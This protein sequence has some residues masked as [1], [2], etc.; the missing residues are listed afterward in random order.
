MMLLIMLMATFF[1]CCHATVYT[2][3]W[4]IK[5]TG[6]QKTVNEIAEK[7]GF[8]NM[9]QVG[10]L[11]SYYSFW[12]NETAKRSTMSNDGLTVS[13]SKETKVKWLQQQFVQ[14]RVKRA[15]GVRQIYSTKHFSSFHLPSKQTMPLHFNNS[16]WSRLWFIHCSDRATGCRTH[17]NIAG[18]WNRGYTGKGV[19]VSVLD[20]G[21][22]G[23]H[24]DLKPNYDPLASY[25]VNR[26]KQTNHITNYH[27]TQCA[28]II[29]A[30]NN[31][32]CTV[33]V[34]FHARIG[35]I[36]I[37]SDDVTDIVE[38]QSLSF[39]PHYIDI[40]LCTWGPEDDGITVEGP[41][42]LT[43]LALQHGV[44]RGRRGR[45]SIFLWASGNG[46][47][48]G[49]H[50]SCDGY[51]SSI[52]TVAISAAMWSRAR[53][54]F[55]E[56]CPSTLTTA[57][58]GGDGQTLMTVGD[59]QTCVE[60]RP[61]SAL[62]ASAAAGVIALTLE[63]NPLLTWRDVQHII[64]RTSKTE[65]LEAPDW[66]IN[67]AGYRVNHLY[68]FGLMDAE[69]MVK[70]AER[71]KQVP[72]QHMCA[73]EA[74]VQQIRTIYPGSVMTSVFEATGCAGNS[75]KHVTYTEHVIL[76]VTITHRRRGNLSIRLISPSGTIS[77]LLAHRPLDNSSEGFQNWE[78]MTTHCWGEPPNGKWTLKI[79]DISSINT[80]ERGALTKWSL[81]IYGTAENPY[82]PRKNVR[83]VEPFDN[84]LLEEY[85]GPCD[86]ECT[87]D[88]C[89]GP[90]PQQCVACLHLFLKFKNGTRLCVSECS[91]GFWGDRRRCK[92]CYATCENCTGSRSDQCTSCQPGHHLTEGTNTCTT[93][94]GEGYYLDHDANMC[95]KCS[96]N[97]L[98][99]TTL[100]ICTECKQ[101][102]SLQGNQC[103]WSCAAGF[104]HD[105][106][107]GKCKPCHKACATCA[108]PGVESCKHCAK[109]YL[110]EEWRCVH[111][112]SV[113]FYATEPSPEMA[114]G[115]R[116]CRRCDASCSACVGPGP[117]NCSRCS[118]GHSHQDGVCVLNTE[119]EEGEY[120]DTDGKCHICDPTCLKCTG[121]QSSNCISCASSR[122]LDD[123]HCVLDCAKGKYQSGGLCYLCDHT[124][125]TCSDSGPTNCTSCDTDKFGMARYLFMGQCV[126]VCPES[127]YHTKE[128]SCE[129]CSDHCQLCSGPTHC[130]KCNSSYY[131]SDGLCNK[132]ECG[133]GEVEDP[134]YDDCMACEEGC[135]KCVLYNPKHCQS[136]IEGFYNF[137]DGCFR[138]CPA[139][140]YSVEEDMTCISCDEKCV[141]CD[142]HEC[143]WCESDL[144][145]SEGR[146]VEV[147]PD[148]FYGD[149]DTNDCEEC[150]SDCVTCSGPEDYDCESCEDGKT[151]ENGLCVFEHEVC[152]V[153]TYRSDDGECEDCH[154]S[155]EA[156]SGDEENQCTKCAKDRFLSPQQTCVMKCP[157]AHFANRLNNV[158]DECSFGCSTCIDTQ[159]CTRCYSSRNSPLYLQNGQCVEQCVRGYPAGL[160]CR[161]CVEGC[162]SCLRN[163]THCLSC[164]APL[165][166]HKHQCVEDC[167]AG[168]TVRD[169]ECH[170]C[171]PACP[172]CNPLGHCIECEE[173]HFL[174]EG[175]CVLDCPERFFADTEQRECSHCH[176]D[177]ALCDGPNNNDC[178]SCVD[179][180]ATLHNGACLTTCT[181][182]TY[183][184]D[185]SGDCN[186][187]DA[188]CLTCSGPY[189]DSCTS[190]RDGYRLEG[191]GHCAP[192]THSQCTVHQYMDQSG[193][194]HPC[195]KYCHRCSGPGTNHC[196]TCNQGHLL[197]NG[198]CFD[199]C[200]TGYY[201]D[202][203]GL[204]CEPCH[205]SCES[206]IGKHSHECLSCKFSLFR[207]AKECVETCQHGHYGNAASRMC[208]K[209]HP[210]CSECLG[211]EDD[212]CLSCT[213][214]LVYLRRAGRCLP[215][216]PEDYHHDA[217]H[218]T[219]EPCHSTCKT[220]LGKES[221]SCQ[222][223]HVGYR[224]SD[225]MC[226]SMCYRG[227]YPVIEGIELACE[228]CD[229][230]CLEC[231]G[232]GP[233]SCTLCPPQ[234]MLEPGGRCL[235]CCSHN[236]DDE[237]ADNKGQLQACC[238]C[239]ESQGECVLS[240]NLAFK[241]DVEDEERG[242]LAV[243]VT[244][245]I[246]LVVVLVAIVFLIR[247][248]RSKSA[249]RD[250]PP[251]G[252]EKLGSGGFGGD[253]HGYS[254]AS[255]TSFGGGQSG[256][257]GGRFQESQM[258]DFSDRRSGNKRND[259][260]DDD[261]ED[262][263]YMGQD[264]TVYRKFK[265]G[266]LGDDNEDE[267]EYDDESYTFR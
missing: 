33:G 262:I 160:V 265:Y 253:R 105:K 123:G 48:S 109:G 192:V 130:L 238:N 219:C 19:V 189:S 82:V 61:S 167:P 45:G 21:V 155:C 244:A 14:K 10:D 127:F 246:L 83:S 135:K 203:M 139:K 111:S 96:E 237:G 38:A 15:S 240:T 80:A 108:G 81:V 76:R 134:D 138:H 73:E 52:Y 74:S 260:D 198:T 207:E 88:G 126:D 157:R 173:Y 256:S 258:V 177:C 214:G 161:S 36:N 197:L 266:Q 254:S 129:P 170:R 252:Y 255:S 102:T 97:C 144:F 106:Q 90:G 164:D 55:Q 172:E 58:S 225:G 95:R 2:N 215:A 71:W 125:I 224:L 120:P 216:C 196:L 8:S 210:S 243:F 11:V 264:G 119:C 31:S 103:L 208:E 152:P 29:A 17:M 251:R 149:E 231:W 35:G 20:D 222:S 128:K 141:S 221:H 163:S 24:L 3:E 145:L 63:A 233:S 37:L 150:N 176:P 78:F 112:C 40:Y 107:E 223:C 70:E 44:K 162:A 121:P 30:A 5:I 199:R 69:S 204:R 263:V 34:S 143:Y 18:A 194:C 179:P 140:T 211:A 187:C 6:D 87:S 26:H 64:V 230:S 13:V 165:L 146:C 213:M 175:Q 54:G 241:N 147:C 153:K 227:Q 249:T 232:Q 46:G 115:Q 72:S 154:P 186:E 57:Y 79:N 259:D 220:C 22:E 101:N 47:Q 148:G 68:G 99:C 59:H 228:D 42:P 168:H 158:C 142:E 151:L 124:C 110:M 32:H 184:D 28:G 200:P 188:S 85:T 4:A 180:E 7:Y 77:E 174:H 201:Q 178:D 257:S 75:L 93:I 89:E 247:H 67:G 56:R 250:I 51:S 190:C 182:H 261:D 132:R 185:I 60:A 159:R 242:N 267:L 156:C 98:K 62:A 191:H 104:Y 166:L 86:A 114:Y 193:E 116:I 202:E 236:N 118:S 94:C 226:E 16:M 122:S 9:G 50:C 245:C 209:C 131:I 181:S 235:L 113:G 1:H 117:E 65:H 53:P 137:Q 133:E 25:D 100:R 66:R 27:G 248:S 183:L 136:C 92:R 91:K 229:A 49:D 12:H 84:E 23:T 171:P 169:G 217:G 43:K 234:A 239:T 195:H 206:C 39:K 41:G 218:G 212:S 205:P